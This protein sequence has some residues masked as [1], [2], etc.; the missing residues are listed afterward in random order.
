[1][2]SFA[3]LHRG[4][5]PLLAAGLAAA[6]V[7]RASVLDSVPAAASQALAKPR[8]A[9]ATFIDRLPDLADLGLPSFAP[10]GAIQL[11][12][13]PK[14]GDLLHEDYF[15]LPVGARFKISEEF[16]LNT[17]LAGYFTHGL[18]DSAGNGLYEGRVGIKHERAFSPESGA[19]SGIDFV[20]PLSR[21][22]RDITD[23]VRHTLPYVTV[24]HTIK[25]SSGLVGF[26]TLG[27]DLLDHTSLPENF[28]KN[29]LHANSLVLTVGVAREWR[30]LHLILKAFDGNTYLLS[31]NHQN[32]FGLRPAVGIPLLRRPDGTPRATATFEGR[33]VWGPDGFET[34]VTT[35]VR[36]DFRY[37]RNERRR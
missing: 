13:H 21:P 30:R 8:L 18:R 20:T 27:A 3:Q 28:R 33:T 35:S 24:T 36:V 17:E 1:M 2:S 37:R 19:S 16:E 31:H 14:F 5:R 4:L 25:P 10:P 6:S 34:G 26:A 29:E 9:L 11:Y 15:R 23:G 12:A 22:P 32:V 7:A